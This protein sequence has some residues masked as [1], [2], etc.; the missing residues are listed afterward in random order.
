[1]IQCAQL[2]RDDVGGLEDRS[3]VRLQSDT[4][5]HIFA[6]AGSDDPLYVGLIH[7]CWTAGHQNFLW[8]RSLNQ[9]MPLWSTMVNKNMPGGSKVASKKKQAV[10]A[11]DLD[12]V[13]VRLPEGMRDK[14]AALAEANGRSMTAEVVAALEQHL[15]GADRLSAVETFVEK[16]RKLIEEL[17]EYREWLIHDLSRDFEKLQGQVTDIDQIVRPNRYDDMK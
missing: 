3:A 1:L 16:H 6:L 12:R 14:V 10:S 11:H 15:K 9:Y 17:E 13:I 7:V 4:E 8:L 2:G 5:G